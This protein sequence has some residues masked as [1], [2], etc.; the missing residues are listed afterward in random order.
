MHTVAYLNGGIQV[1]KL[2]LCSFLHKSTAQSNE[3]YIMSECSDNFPQ[4]GT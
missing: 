3:V 2:T 4:Q 1:L